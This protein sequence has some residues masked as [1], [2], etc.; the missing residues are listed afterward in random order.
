MEHFCQ[1]QR[2]FLSLIW[3]YLDLCKCIRVIIRMEFFRRAS[4]LICTQT[5]WLCCHTL[6]SCSLYLLMDSII[7]SGYG[8]YMFYALLLLD[9]SAVVKFLHLCDRLL[10]DLLDHIIK[11]ALVDLFHTFLQMLTFRCDIFTGET[12]CQKAYHRM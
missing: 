3:S 6:C 7:F 11:F 8:A 2:C 4:F 12:S 9:F 1:L 10:H 5:S